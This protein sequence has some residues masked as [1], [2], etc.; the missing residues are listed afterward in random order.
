MVSGIL[1]VSVVARINITCLG[2]SSIVLRS[3][4]QACFESICASSKIYTLYFDS[5]GRVLTDSFNARISS[6]PVFDA[7]SISKISFDV[8]P[9]SFAKTRAILVLPV[10]REP[11]KIYA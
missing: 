11:A 3:A 6:T 7:A 9:I 5:K 1:F 2:G 4:F 10:P 8:V